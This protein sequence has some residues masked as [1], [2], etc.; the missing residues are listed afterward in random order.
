IKNKDNLEFEINVSSERLKQSIQLREFLKESSVEIDTTQILLGS[1]HL[2]VF[3]PFYSFDPTFED[4]K[5][6]GGLNLIKNG[7]VKDIIRAYLFR[8]NLFKSMLYNQSQTIKQEYNNTLYD[9]LNP[10]IKSYWWK[11]G[12]LDKSNASL[13]DLKDFG[14]DLEGL[15]I[16]RKYKSNLKKVIGIE[17]ELKVWYQI[18][19]KEN[20]QPAI[21]LINLEI[22]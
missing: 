17:R 8:V 18:L 5:S 16:N 6:S 9:Y 4:L 7:D 21:D 13:E 20:L 15:K 12:L 11:K 2:G 1:V 19:L 3:S 22:K 14:F 10:E